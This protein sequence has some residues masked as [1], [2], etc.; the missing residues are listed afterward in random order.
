M[1]S[2]RCIIV[3][4]GNVIAF[5][6]HRKAARQLAVLGRTPL[7][8]QQVYRAIFQTRL[9]EDY[10]S[11]RVSTAAFIEQLRVELDLEASDGEIGRAWNDIYTPNTAM[12]DVIDEIDRRG[13]RLILA[14]NTNELHYQ[15]FRP[16]FAPTL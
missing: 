4:F 10:D 12:L 14:S 11:G 3:D 9:E 5:F 8:A 2:P 15:W 1:A 16:R 6:D 7:D 13:A